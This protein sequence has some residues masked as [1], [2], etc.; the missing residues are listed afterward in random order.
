MLG[1]T[2]GHVWTF[3]ELAPLQGHTVAP[4]NAVRIALQLLLAALLLTA[5]YYRLT[6]HDAGR[7]YLLFGAWTVTLAIC[8]FRYGKN[9]N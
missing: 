7:Y 4:G 3:D 6:R 1:K 8:V 2:T 5:A 9:S